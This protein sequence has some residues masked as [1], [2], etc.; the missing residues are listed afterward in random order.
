MTFFLFSLRRRTWS[1]FST[2]KFFCSSCAGEFS[3]HFVCGKSLHGTVFFCV[4]FF[5]EKKFFYEKKIFLRIFFPEVGKPSTE[6]SREYKNCGF[7]QKCGRLEALMFLS[8]S[9][10]IKFG[11]SVFEKCFLSS[12][13]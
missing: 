5:T 13:N 6:I 2:K 1:P 3:R 7:P 12:K 9:Q 11:K 4:F 10:E 8:H